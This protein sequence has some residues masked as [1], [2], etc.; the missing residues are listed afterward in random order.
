MPGSLLWR[1]ASG[2]KRPLLKRSAFFFKDV[3]TEMPD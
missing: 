2:A 1:S 3:P